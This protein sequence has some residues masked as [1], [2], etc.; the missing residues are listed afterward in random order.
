MFNKVL[1][2]RI[3]GIISFLKMPY[4]NQE[5]RSELDNHL[6]PLLQQHFTVGEMN[7][8]I[9]KL[10]LNYMQ[11]TGLC[12]DVCNSLVGV[13]ECAKMEL[14]RRLVGPYEDTKVSENGDVY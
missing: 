10:V 9:T 5:K 3:L 4:I 7:Y 2:L 14:Y 11:K 12:Y 8:V 6:N 1:V 13:L